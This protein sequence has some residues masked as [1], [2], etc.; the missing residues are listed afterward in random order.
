VVSVFS[1]GASSAASSGAA[2]AESEFSS[3]TYDH[4]LW[5]TTTIDPS[6]RADPTGR[7]FTYFVL[8]SG[9]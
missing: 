5:S 9:R 8:G 1:R 4:K 6:T 2:T 3:D 7:D